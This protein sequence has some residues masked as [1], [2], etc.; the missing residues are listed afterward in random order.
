MLVV[1]SVIASGCVG[2]GGRSS[3][4]SSEVRAFF[5][6]YAF[7]I[8]TQNTDKLTEMYQLPLKLTAANSSVEVT[9]SSEVDLYDYVDVRTY[10]GL[11][12]TVDDVRLVVESVNG[13]GNNANAKISLIID[14]TSDGEYDF[15]WRDVYE[16]EMTLRKSGGEWKI[17]AEHIN[18][19]EFGAR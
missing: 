9:I 11:G 7:R 12:W 15:K 4:A 16:L 13:S 10:E 3:F 6:L 8:E 18:K 1:L 5:D 19:S 2:G 14:T 17:V